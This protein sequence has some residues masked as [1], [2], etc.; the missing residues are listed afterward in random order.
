MLKKYVNI[1][2]LG[3]LLV[4]VFTS[5]ASDSTNDTTDKKEWKLKVVTTTTMITDLLQQ[6]GGDQIEVQ[7]LMGAGVDPHY[8]KA[9]Q[10]DVSK[11][12]EADIIFYN[13]LHLEGSMAKVLD[14]MS[15]TNKNTVPLADFIP[16]NELISNPDF[17]GNYDPHVW[18]DIDFWT[19]MAEK[20]AEELVKADPNNAASYNKRKDDY[21]TKLSNLKKDLKAKIQELPADQ[22]RLVTAH[23]AF[24]YF[25]REFDFNVEGLQ[26][27][28]TVA[29]AGV[30]DVQRLAK[31]IVDE[32]VKAIF[33]ESSVPVRTIES[34]KEAVKHKGH[35]VVIGG[36]LFSDALG[37]PGTPDGTYT[38]MYEHNVNTIVNALK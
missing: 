10:G 22:R 16:K 8:Y 7:G 25:A 32:N 27:I 1:S 11:L 2:F 19:L 37:S 35:E 36:E 18:F 14:N 15:K 17:K 21:V 33:I 29:E 3:L 12:T 9:S 20:A 23:D 38:G 34:L 13:G 26:G 30:Q 4:T 6:L 24:S 28:S 31:Y 5:C